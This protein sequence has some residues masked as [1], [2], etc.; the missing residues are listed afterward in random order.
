VWGGAVSTDLSEG[1]T[2]GAYHIA[3]VGPLGFPDSR[4]T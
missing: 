1:Q 3:G 4:L 2:F